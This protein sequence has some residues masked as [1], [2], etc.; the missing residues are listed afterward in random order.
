MLRVDPSFGIAGIGRYLSDHWAGI[1]YN[2]ECHQHNTIR[3]G[4]KRRGSEG[5]ALSA[6]FEEDLGQI[7]RLLG[8]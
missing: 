4:V 6:H 3:L 1:P 5:D 8:E 7:P 2:E